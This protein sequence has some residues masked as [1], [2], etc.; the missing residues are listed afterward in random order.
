MVNLK[1]LLIDGRLAEIKTREERKEFNDSERDKSYEEATD[2][3]L[4][5][6]VSRIF[7]SFAVMV[8]SA[9]DV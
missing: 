3:I 5:I 1:Y 2:V 6:H 4:C 9:I 7:D 8:Y